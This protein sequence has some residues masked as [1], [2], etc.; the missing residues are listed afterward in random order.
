MIFFANIK[1]PPS[2]TKIERGSC[3]DM[4]LIMDPGK[5]FL[6]VVDGDT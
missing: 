5:G 1:K 3:H 6:R 2:I 4:I